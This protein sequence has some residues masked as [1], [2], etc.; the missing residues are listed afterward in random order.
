MRLVLAIA[1]LAAFLVAMFGSAQAPAAMPAPAAAAPAPGSSA[2]APADAALA[3]H[4]APSRATPALPVADALHAVESSVQAARQRG[5][6]ENEIHQLRAS[7]LTAAQLEALIAMEA[8][9]ASWQR[10]VTELRERCGTREACG[11]SL[12]PEERARWRSYAE[13]ALRQ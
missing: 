11:A 8:A 13:A 4:P 3:A 7:R 6:G 1:A 12:A 10:R 5:A 9:E 2:R